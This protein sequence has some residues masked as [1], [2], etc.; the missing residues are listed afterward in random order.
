MEAEPRAESRR[1]WDED[2]DTGPGVGRRGRDTVVIRL[3]EIDPEL[4]AWFREMLPGRSLFRVLRDPPDDVIAHVRN[5]RRERLLAIRSLVDALIED[6][7][8]P[9]TRRS[10]EIEIE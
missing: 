2:E 3:P 1:A 4:R 5:A 10:R 9:R 6:A 7:E 8:R